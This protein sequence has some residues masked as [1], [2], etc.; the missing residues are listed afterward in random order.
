[1]DC[2]AADC[3]GV[4]LYVDRENDRAQQTYTALGMSPSSYDLYEID[5][6]LG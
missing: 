5:F 4:R 1:M 6:V 2:A 3:C